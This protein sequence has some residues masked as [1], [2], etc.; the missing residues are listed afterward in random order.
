MKRVYLLALLA[1]ASY[2]AVVG[3]QGEPVTML[4][5]GDVTLAHHIEREVGDKVD[6]I[7]EHWNQVGAYD[8]FMVNLE[9][10]VTRSTG[11]VEKE[12]N[13]RMPPR[14]LR[15]LK[16]AA[17]NVVNLA[18][19]HI[20]DFGIQGLYDTFANLDSAG[21]R[22]V[23]AGRDIGEARTPVLI[24]LKGKRIG[25][26]GYYGSGKWAATPTRAG[27]APR[28]EPSVI[29]DVR[30]LRD[31]VDYLVVNF[32]WGEESAERPSPELIRLAHRVVDAGADLIVGHHPHTLQG[33]ERY[34]GKVIA[35][36]LGNF[37]FGGNSRRSY[38]TAVLRVLL[39]DTTQ[40][41][42]LVPVQVINW[43]PQV[44]QR[45]NAEVIFRRVRD[46]SAIF[47]ESISFPS[48][49]TE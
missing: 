43:Q 38:G 36:S 29:S 26:L 13:F 22:Y 35:Y 37:V 41:V 2:A 11:K 46:R 19:N 17:I 12:F 25:I 27:V 45:S 21:I 6:Y 1:S 18:N 42:E 47:S 28:H 30:K 40:E 3:Q 23:G 10:P 16:N 15:T 49:A 48:G 5:A 39:G 31:S 9:N 34:K 24:D 33:I 32:H 8:L 20:V 7:F 44:A 14:Y 4:F